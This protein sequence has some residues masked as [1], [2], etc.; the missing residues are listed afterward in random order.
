MN[1]F[2]TIVELIGGIACAAVVTDTIF[3]VVYGTVERYAFGI[4]REIN[5]LTSL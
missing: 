1:I 3:S 2:Q 5:R 4:K